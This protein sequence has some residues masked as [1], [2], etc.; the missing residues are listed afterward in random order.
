V[1]AVNTFP[2]N[3]VP[4]SESLKKQLWLLMAYLVRISEGNSRFN[5]QKYADLMKL[6]CR[7]VLLDGGSAVDAAIASLFCIGVVHPHSAGIGG[8]FLMT[9]YDSKTGKAQ[10]LNS[11][12]VAPLA[13]T[14]NMFG[15][16][17]N[18][19]TKGL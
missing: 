10:C 7:N 19:S 5:E 16:N 8:G 3:H 13:A 12:E 14:E 1:N 15:G 11:R 18:L 6:S 9:V 2:R 17:S 4:D